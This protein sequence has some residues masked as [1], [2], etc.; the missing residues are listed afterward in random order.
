MASLPDQPASLLSQRQDLL[1]DC[2]IASF[3]WLTILGF[4]FLTFNSGMAIYRSELDPETILF[5][6]V[7]YIL[8]LLLVYCLKRF[9]GAPRNSLERDRLKASVWALTMLLTLAFAYVVM[10][11]AKL[12]LPV[13]LL[14][15]AT[16]GGT[17]IG[18]FYAFF[19]RHRFIEPRYRGI[20][21]IVQELP[22]Q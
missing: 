8:L 4:V 17:G 16:A 13:A 12:S 21:P 6:G 10:G 1:E 9:E 14:V 11:V 19:Q 7:S 2:R 5:V 15:W 18:A 3:P 22:R 20:L